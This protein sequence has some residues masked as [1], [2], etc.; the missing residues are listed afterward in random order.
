MVRR[1]STVRFRNG[2]Q[3]SG[4][5]PNGPDARRGTDDL[6][7]VIVPTAMA[8][9]SKGHKSNCPVMP[10]GSASTPE[11]IQSP[12]KKPPEGDLSRRGGRDG[13]PRLAAYWKPPFYLLEDAIE[14][15]VVNARDVKNVPGRP[16]CWQPS[17]PA[18][19]GRPG[20]ATQARR[21]G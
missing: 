15:W 10:C 16:K 4:A 2:L 1:R 13:C 9:T 18:G 7:S 14:C 20:R 21:C 11:L 19:S 12:A 8:R 6:H 5:F 3:L 17:W